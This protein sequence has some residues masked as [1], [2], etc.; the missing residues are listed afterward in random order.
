MYVSMHTEICIHTLVQR[1]RFVTHIRDRHAHRKAH[2]HTHT[3]THT[4]RF[5]V[6]NNIF[7]FVV[8][9]LCR[10]DVALCRDGSVDVEKCREFK[11]KEPVSRSLS[12]VLFSTLS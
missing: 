12:S 2:T 8:V 4:Q 10:L 1:H 7:H 9:L 11:G 6:S 5:T 3:H